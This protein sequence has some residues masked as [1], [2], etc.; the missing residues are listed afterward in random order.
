MASLLLQW[1]DGTGLLAAGGLRPTGCEPGGVLLDPLGNEARRAAREGSLD[2]L[3][4]RD[5]D[6]GLVLAVAGVDMR[7]RVVLVVEVDGYA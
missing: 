4:G 7:R 1:L 5:V 3:T 6:L 2:A